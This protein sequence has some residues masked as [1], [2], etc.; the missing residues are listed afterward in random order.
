MLTTNNVTSRDSIAP[1]VT[2]CVRVSLA[3]FS[4]S[5]QQ[6]CADHDRQTG[7]GVGPQEYTLIK[8]EVLKPFPAPLRQLEQANKVRYALHHAMVILPLPIVL[9]LRGGHTD[10]IALVTSTNSVCSWWLLL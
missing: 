1:H 10:V 5:N 3:I 7:E 2:C 8:L 9:W 4:P 6:P